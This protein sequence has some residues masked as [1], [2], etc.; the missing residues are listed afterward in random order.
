LAGRLLIVMGYVGVVLGTVGVCALAIEASRPDIRLGA[1]A[2]GALLFLGGRIAILRG[3]KLMLVSAPVAHPR[4]DNPRGPVLYLR[5]FQDDPLTARIPPTPRIQTEEEMLANVLRD[6]GP[7]TAIGRPG[8]PLPELG[9]SRFYVSN[10]EWQQAVTD[11]L[12]RAVLVVARAGATD[13]LRWELE[14]IVR[15]VDP[16][17][18]VLLLPFQGDEYETFRARAAIFPHGLPERFTI[19]AWTRGELDGLSLYA[20]VRFD[21]DWTPNL[22]KLSRELRGRLP[23]YWWSR[24][25]PIETYLRLATRPVLDQLGIA[26]GE[27]PLQSRQL[28]WSAIMKSAF[29][30]TVV[31]LMLTAIVVAMLAPDVGR[32]IHHWMTDRGW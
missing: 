7:V 8:E 6:V 24:Q 26:A 21:E 31:A 1:T 11:L 22:V 16:A 3:R 2:G 23:W 10:A 14:Q 4:G 19:G 28:R 30:V 18:L 27:H 20:L 5:S 25:I 9:A 12:R 15:R 32:A 13:G 29:M 17:R